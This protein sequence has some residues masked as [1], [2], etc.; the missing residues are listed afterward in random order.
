[1]IEKY[2]IWKF[3]NQEHTTAP[4][5][6]AI[7]IVTFITCLQCLPEKSTKVSIRLQG[8]AD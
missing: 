7:N 6:K 3:S 8:Q 4:T 1:M 2:H 5:S